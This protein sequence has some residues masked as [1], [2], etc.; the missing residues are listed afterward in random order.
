MIIF[1][2]D[3]IM[4]NAVDHNSEQASLFFKNEKGYKKLRWKYSKNSKL[5]FIDLFAG[6]GGF[7][8]PF[9]RVGA[10]CV[11]A[12]EWDEPARKTYDA[13]WRAVSPEMFE[14]YMID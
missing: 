11:F 3:S 2:K 8:L 13:N 10:E 1:N 4:H 14:K 6:I 7:H 9:H 5:R 12:S